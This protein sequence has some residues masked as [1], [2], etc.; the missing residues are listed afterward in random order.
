MT[1]QQRA[2]G[3]EKAVMS[4]NADPDDLAAVVRDALETIRATP[5]K[6]TT[7]ERA[8]KVIRSNGT[9]RDVAALR[10]EIGGQF[11]S[12]A[13]SLPALRASEPEATARQLPCF[14]RVLRQ[15]IPGWHTAVVLIVAAIL[16]FAAAAQTGLSPGAAA[17]STTGI[18]KADDRAPIGLTSTQR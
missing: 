11:A 10:R 9:A 12:A 3:R 17:Q 18:N 5:Q 2:G 6:A 16:S 14:A 4:A 13:D 8:K 1:G 7:L 15:T